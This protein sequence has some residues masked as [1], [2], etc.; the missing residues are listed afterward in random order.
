VYRLDA[1]V[2]DSW[3]YRDKEVVG[4]FVCFRAPLWIPTSPRLDT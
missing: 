3:A 2:Y 4:V 1:G